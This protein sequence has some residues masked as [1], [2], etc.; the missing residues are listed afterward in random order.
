MLDPRKS[1]D[2]KNWAAN[3]AN[4]ILMAQ[5]SNRTVSSNFITESKLRKDTLLAN[6]PSFPISFV[7]TGQTPNASEILLAQNDAFLATSIRL[8]VKKLTATPTDILHVQ[9]REYT[10][11]NIFVFD[12]AAEVLAIFGLWN[13]K[14]SITQ[15]S[16]VRFPKLWTGDL[17]FA[18]EQQY[19]DITAAF[20]GPTY[21]RKI[22]DSK[23]SPNFGFFEIEPVLFTGTDQT[24]MLLNYG[25]ALNIVEAAE[26]NYFTITLGGFLI[27]GQ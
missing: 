5:G 13:A 12:G 18:P 19:G 24:T 23:Q 7:A 17:L 3:A 6:Q 20:T 25:A 26:Y 4:G 2:L 1:V 10:Y 15:N 16:S 14:L 27:S 9:A 21:G 22:G 8:S 11:P